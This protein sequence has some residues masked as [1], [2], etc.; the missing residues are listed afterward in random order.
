MIREASAELRLTLHFISGANCF[1]YT[2]FGHF[3]VDALPIR[4]RG[5][6]GPG[7]CPSFRA[8]VTLYGYVRDARS[9][10]NWN[11]VN[12]HGCLG[13]WDE[14]NQECR[15]NGMGRSRSTAYDMSN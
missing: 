1:F 12:A 14:G 13:A 3:G 7:P 4:L 11:I 2:F 8:W 10:D 6:D 15:N 9:L 5:V